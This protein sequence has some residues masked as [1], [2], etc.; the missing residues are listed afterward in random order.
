MA[1]TFSG[2]GEIPWQSMWCPRK[3]RESAANKHLFG[4]MRIP[5]AERRVN[6]AFKSFKCCSGVELAMSTSSM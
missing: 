3:L 5:W 1:L 6:T 2:T 4:L